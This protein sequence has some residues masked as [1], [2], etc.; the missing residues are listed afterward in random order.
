MAGTAL[1][2][3]EVSCV[4]MCT[5]PA[6]VFTT[7]STAGSVDINAMLNRLRARCH[8]GRALNVGWVHRVPVTTPLQ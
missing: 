7:S 5:E 8:L 2:K 3:L 1:A 4:Y 6:G